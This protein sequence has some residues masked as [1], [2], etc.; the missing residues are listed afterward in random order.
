MC[1]TC[2]AV[3][4]L[5]ITYRIAA[6]TSCLKLD[7]VYRWECQSIRDTSQLL[8]D[9]SL[10]QLSGEDPQRNLLKSRHSGFVVQTCHDLLWV[11]PI[12]VLGSPDVFI[13]RRFRVF[14]DDP[15][16]FKTFQLRGFA[17]VWYSHK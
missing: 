17:F 5:C 11:V 14:L 3:L 7:C 15:G 12:V 10:E 16:C 1:H 4:H 8:V 13:S 6:Y 2:F 9:Q